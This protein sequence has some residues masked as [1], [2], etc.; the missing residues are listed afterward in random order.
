MRRPKYLISKISHNTCMFL[1]LLSSL[2]RIH[3][4]YKTNQINRFN[5]V[6]RIF[7]G[8]KMSRHCLHIQAT[9]LQATASCVGAAAAS[10]RGYNYD[11]GWWHA[12]SFLEISSLGQPL[13]LSSYYQ[14]L[15]VVGCS[16]QAL[17]RCWCMQL[18]ECSYIIS[19]PSTLGIWWGTSEIWRK[20]ARAVENWQGRVGRR[21]C[22]RSKRQVWVKRLYHSDCIIR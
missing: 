3:N 17:L 22:A 10:D 11:N 19:L 8:G 20:M 5:M 9:I 6:C 2:C 1:F 15:R 16:R 4:M 18:T 13:V 14:L 12:S 21:C 7:Q